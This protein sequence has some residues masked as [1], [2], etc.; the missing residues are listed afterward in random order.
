MVEIEQLKQQLKKINAEAAKIR[1][2]S[3]EKRAEF[4]R[5]LNAKRQEVLN[6]IAQ[7]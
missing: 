4:G 3:V 7:A 5:A 6:K 1:E 2:L